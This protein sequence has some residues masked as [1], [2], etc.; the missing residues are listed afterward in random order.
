MVSSCRSVV[1]ARSTA[2]LP[3]CRGLDEV[4]PVGSSDASYNHSC[5][6]AKLGRH[7]SP[8]RSMGPS[9]RCCSHGTVIQMTFGFNFEFSPSS[10]STGVQDPRLRHLLKRGHRGGR[11]QA[12]TIPPPERSNPPTWPPRFFSAV[13]TKI[14]QL[15]LL[16]VTHNLEQSLKDSFQNAELLGQTQGT[17]HSEP[18]G[19]P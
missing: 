11:R 4:Y 15:S 14:N 5:C 17:H 13:S 6:R 1:L 12:L 7:L 9:V 3:G 8:N 18:Q 19:A 10:N 2:S 16:I